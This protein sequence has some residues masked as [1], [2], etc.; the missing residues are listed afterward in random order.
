MILVSV[1]YP[2]GAF[3]HDYYLKKHIPL[4]QARWQGMGLKEVRVLR[5]VG[6]PGGAAATYQVITLLTFS[7]LQDFQKCTAAHGEEIFADIPN[8]TSVQPVVQLNEP[9]G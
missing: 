3:N 6:A 1:L 4:V 5:G 9:M 2:S 8:F 7:S